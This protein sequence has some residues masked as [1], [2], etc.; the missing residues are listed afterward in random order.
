MAT[1]A[2]IILIILTIVVAVILFRA[3]F[4]HPLAGLPYVGFS[5]GEIVKTR[6]DVPPRIL[7]EVIDIARCARA[8]GTITFNDPYHASFSSGFPE[9]LQQRIRN[10]LAMH[11]GPGQTSG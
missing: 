5:D 9:P 7:R 4:S 10:V 11:R 3:G 8:T 1:Y 6:G 2:G